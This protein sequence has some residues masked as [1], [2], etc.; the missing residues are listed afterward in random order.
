MARVRR[1]TLVLISL[2]MFAVLAPAANAAPYQFAPAVAYGVG[3][4]P[5]DIARADL[6]G[7]T[8]LDLATPNR[9]STN[10]SV[11]LNEGDGTFAASDSYAAGPF[12]WSIAAGRLDDDADVDLAV[13]DTADN[14]VLVLLNEGDGGFTTGQATVVGDDPRAV[15]AGDLNGDGVPDLVT[16]NFD[17]DTVSVLLGNGDG[18]L[19]DRQPYSAGINASAADVATGDVDRDGIVDLVVGDTGN[20]DISILRGTGNGTFGTAQDFRDGDP[21]FPNALVVANL[22][23]D[24]RPDVAEANALNNTVGVLLAKLPSATTLQVDLGPEKIRAV[25]RVKPNH[26]GEPVFVLLEK[27]KADGTWKQLDFHV[28]TLNAESRYAVGFERPPAQRCRVTTLFP[29]DEDH[30]ASKARKSFAC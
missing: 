2:A 30:M 17:D 19:Q 11:L 22:N 13:T 28:R 15:A 21:L 7:D 26:A 18:S 5:N 12:P 14:E 4:V 25:G 3:T 23:G 24:I 27:K 20:R 6:D 1:S 9:G 16:A 29:G 10:V 8:D